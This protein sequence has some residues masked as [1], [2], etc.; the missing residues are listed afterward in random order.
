M[1]STFIPETALQRAAELRTLLEYHNRKYY[2][3]DDPEIT[4]AEYDALFRELVAL[5]TEYSELDDP[6]SPT[7]R[8][9]G[10]VA[11]GFTSAPHAESMLSLD[12]AM[13]S[14]EKERLL[15]CI[16][17]LRKQTA[18][19]RDLIE[20]VEKSQIGQIV[21][22]IKRLHDQIENAIAPVRPA[23]ESVNQVQRFVESYKSAFKVSFA[24]SFSRIQELREKEKQREELGKPSKFLKK[25]DGHLDATEIA[26]KRLS[27]VTG[28]VDP[29]S[30]LSFAQWRDFADDKLTNA[31]VDRVQLAAYAELE[32]SIQRSFSSKERTKYLP[33][34][35]RAVRDH[36]LSENGSNR[37]S[38]ERVLKDILS[39]LNSSSL[40]SYTKEGSFD[41]VTVPGIVWANPANAL[42][43]FWADP[44]MDGLALEVV[45]EQGK[46][47]RAIT[48]GD[49][50]VG[51]VVT[52][53]MRTVR[54]LP[55]TL[56][57][58][59]PDML[60]VRGEVV[61]SAKGF[62][63]L[64]QTQEEEGRKPFA[65]PRN[66]A[67]GSIRQLDSSI[68][69]SR[70][71]VFLAYGVGTAPGA[72]SHGW[73]TQSEV[74]ASLE[75]YGF[76]TPPDARLCAAPKAV[77]EHFSFLYSA[78]DDLDYEID[79]VVAKLDDRSLQ[80]FIGNTARAPRWAIALKFPAHRTLTRL[81][82][83]TIQV[84]RTGVLTPVAELEPVRVGGV[85]VSR[86]TLHNFD[87]LAKKKLSIGDMVV[88]QRAGD[89]IP[90]IVGTDPPKP[91]DAQSTIPIP[92][93]CPVCDGA[94][95]RPEGEV[96][97]RCTNL[98]CPAQ[99]EQALVHFVSKA[100]LDMDG[101]GKESV[102]RLA[103]DG[104]LASPA[105][106]FTLEASTLAA[107]D[108]M[109]EKSSQNFVES[110]EIART[111]TTLARL[112][113]GLGIRH[114]GEQTAKALAARYADMDA[115]ADVADPD[116]KIDE[117]TALDD[118][119]EVVAKSIVSWFSNESNQQL[120]VRFKK[121]ELW[122]KG[123]GGGDDASPG[124]KPLSGIKLVFTGSIPVPR[125]KAEQMAE[126]AGG[127]AMKSV[128]KKTDYLVAGA[129]AGSKLA[130]AEGL[131]VTII[132]YEAFLELLKSEE[133]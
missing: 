97:L 120:L 77:E 3:L 131:G 22:E 28:G 122:P 52:A 50:T 29:S 23:I 19:L 100:G 68:A 58:D 51:E 80:D 96:A 49:G 84:G 45:Y 62:H 54:N 94:V 78:R 113:A 39:K 5:E 65:N 95:S 60:E 126:A 48:R 124:S 125:S 41:F 81:N 121:L 110:I 20:S 117:L 91:E 86:A 56:A 9:G 98:S 101:V 104:K 87:E 59:Y 99:V 67:A 10:E 4:D 74:M 89:V 43:R 36:L 70:P 31:F 72:A 66:A 90:Q 107:Y 85:E 12:N 8:V 105:D 132:D 24:K 7:K 108:R 129:G 15:D 71:L 73:C 61:M 92:E 64:N 6:N 128:S 35:G 116:A 102:K 32:Q 75:S 79:G 40:L 34:I 76:T 27:E 127:Q 114:V 111:S 133:I 63:K 25:I 42:G 93:K 2:V 106:L 17:A 11:D 88:L 13:V 30:L 26:V 44:K 33:V 46:L 115:L 53:N 112:I 119:G 37:K 16:N 21:G 69:A 83:V 55:L 82:E 14:S 1:H 47:V 123:S 130:K 118:V 18:P 103:R 38:F 57:G 109:G